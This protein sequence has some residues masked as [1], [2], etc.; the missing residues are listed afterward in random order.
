MSYAIV[1]LSK[2]INGLHFFI[3]AL[4]AGIKLIFCV[5]AVDQSFFCHYNFAFIAF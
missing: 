1:Y 4:I 2:N 3:A 5:A